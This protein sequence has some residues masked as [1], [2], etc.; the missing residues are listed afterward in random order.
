MI[1]NYFAIECPYS[2]IFCFSQLQV[3]NEKNHKKE[4]FST[5]FRHDLHILCLTSPICCWFGQIHFDIYSSLTK[6][7]VLYDHL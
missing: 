4:S 3:K 6:S 7:W 2:F 1:S 5:L